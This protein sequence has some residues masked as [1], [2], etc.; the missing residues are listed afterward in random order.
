M[1]ILS[2]NSVAEFL[3]REFALVTIRTGLYYIFRQSISMKETD[4]EIMDRNS[5]SDCLKASIDLVS[6]YMCDI[7]FSGSQY[8]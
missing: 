2:S 5:T 4:S 6:P 8:Q 3:L 7:I 1:G